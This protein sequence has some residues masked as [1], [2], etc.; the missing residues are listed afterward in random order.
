[1]SGLIA[2]VGP[3]SFQLAFQIS[4]IIMVGGLA[5]NIPGGMLPLLTILDAAGFIGGILGTGSLPSL[6]QAFA[7]FQ[8]IQGTTLLE[9]EVGHYPFANQQVAANAMIAQPLQLYML[10]KCP[11]TVA[12]GGYPFKLGAMTALQIAVTQHNASGGTYMALTPSQ[13]YTNLLLK[14]IH[15][16]TSGQEKQVQTM[17]QWDFEQPLLTVSAAQQVQNSLMSQMT[18]G[19]STGSQPAW[20]GAGAAVSNPNAAVAPSVIPSAGSAVSGSPQI[21]TS[22]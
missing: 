18:G 14:R 3:S 12:A 20:S 6:D 11:A 1:M 17:W 4:P 13:I 7:Q 22:P 15:D 5:Q 8:P 9:W 16:V 2:A 10:M 21:P 19:T